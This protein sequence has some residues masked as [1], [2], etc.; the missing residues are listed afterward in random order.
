MKK[1][2]AGFF[3]KLWK[4][5]SGASHIVEIILVIVVVIALAG[6][7]L[8]RLSSSVNRTVDILDSEIGAEY[9]IETEVPY[10]S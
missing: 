8:T 9:S 5:E 4:E 1:K 7:L 6:I 2:I 3:R 10:V